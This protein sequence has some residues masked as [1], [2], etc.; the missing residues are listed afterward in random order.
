MSD[1]KL[2]SSKLDSH[3]LQAYY[4]VYGGIPALVK[5]TYLW[6]SIAITAMAF[7]AWSPPSAEWFDTVISVLPN[8][9]GFSIGGFAIF[10]SIGDEQYRQV[11]CGQDEPDRPS[12]Y[13]EVAATF[14]HFVTV[15]VLAL[16]LAAV[17]KS[18]PIASMHLDSSWLETLQPFAWLFRAV[19]Y[20]TFIY[21]LVL[22]LAAIEA[23]WR[24]ARTYDRHVS[25]R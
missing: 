12:P 7:G 8:L 14:M 15:Q 9:L 20:V 10:L 3:P 24:V 22:C 25:R 6:I 5:S 1:E 23:I 21:A 19:S 4:V 11:I 13:M 16:L 17:G 18:H 2:P